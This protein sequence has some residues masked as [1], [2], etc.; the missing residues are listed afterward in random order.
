MLLYSY[1]KAYPFTYQQGI[2]YS[3]QVNG[4]DVSSSTH[5]GAIKLLVTS[6]D[7]LKVLIRHEPPPDGLKVLA[8]LA[9]RHIESFMQE[10]TLVTKPGEGFGFSIAGGVNGDPANPFDETDE[11]IFVSEVVPGGA[12][13][14]DG[15]LAVGIR[16]LQVQQ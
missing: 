9:R 12:V 8:T 2:L 10:L 5:E 16:I 1:F 13:A 4:V 3:L 6:G 11:G 15:R 7:P 14:R